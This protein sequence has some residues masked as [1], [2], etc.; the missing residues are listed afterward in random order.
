MLLWALIAGVVWG[1]AGCNGQKDNATEKAAVAFNDSL[2]AAQSE[3]TYA[4]ARFWTVVDTGDAE[5]LR[6]AL[7]QVQRQVEASREQV[8]RL[9]PVAHGD[10]MRRQMLEL[11]RFYERTTQ[12][13]YN[14]IVELLVQHADDD[15]L[16]EPVIQEID[17]LMANVARRERPYDSSFQAAQQVYAR[18]YGFEVE[19]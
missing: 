14:R 18:Q 13:E 4:V 10:S 19:D 12:N 6:P 2:V 5:D 16:P 3:V 15:S 17:S 1:L 7:Q 9:E 8:K 11:F